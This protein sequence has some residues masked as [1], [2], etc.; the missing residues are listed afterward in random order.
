MSQRIQ[1]T[2]HAATPHPSNGPNEPDRVQTRA[3]RAAKANQ[4]GTK[5]KVDEIASQPQTN[6]GSWPKF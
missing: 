6:T 2:S 3:Q 1:E 5:R 4:N